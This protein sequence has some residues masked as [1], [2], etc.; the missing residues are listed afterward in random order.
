MNIN[1]QKKVKKG[2]TMIKLSPSV[3]AADF[4]C[5]KDEIKKISGADYVHIDVM[6][7]HFVPNIT[8]GPD[9][10]K[11]IKKHTNLVL[12]VHLMIENPEKYVDVFLKS[13]ADIITVHYECNMDF[14]Y[15]KNA[16]KSAGKKLGLSIKPK[17]DAEVLEKFLPDID[18]A[19]VMS[20]E[21]GFGGQKFM[22]ESIDKIKKIRLMDKNIDIEVDGGIGEDNIKSVVD[23]GANVIV[24]G[25]SV[26]R[27]D[28][29]KKAVENL[30]KF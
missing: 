18:M 20:V 10:V 8:F 2:I 19:L 11:C 4:A 17:T 1:R 30:K 23:A 27:A 22:P 12:D 24:A 3:L 14:E 13:G 15:I 25:S 6:D 9:I 16:V 21:P 29:V 26:F 7:G 5:L 28:D